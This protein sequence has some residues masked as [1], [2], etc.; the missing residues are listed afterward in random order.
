MDHEFRH[1]IVKVAIAVDPRG[2]NRVD[3]QTLTF[4]VLRR[5]HNKTCNTHEKLTSNNFST[6]T[7]CQIVGFRSDWLSIIIY[8]FMCLPAY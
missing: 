5:I 7:I 6:A 8:K 3:P 1:N 4:T 2:D